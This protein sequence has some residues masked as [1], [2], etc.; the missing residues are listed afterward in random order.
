MGTPQPSYGPPKLVESRGIEGFPPNNENPKIE[1]LYL[2]IWEG[3]EK[4]KNH[5]GFICKNPPPNPIEKCLK[6][7]T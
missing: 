6:T 5:E 2:R 3:N 7:A 4:E 1:P